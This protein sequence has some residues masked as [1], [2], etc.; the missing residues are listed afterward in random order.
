MMELSPILGILL[1]LRNEF[2]PFAMKLNVEWLE[3]EMT[4]KTPKAM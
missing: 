1:L 2:I 4:I 3:K